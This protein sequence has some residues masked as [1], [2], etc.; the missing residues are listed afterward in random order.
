[1]PCTGDQFSICGDSSR[2]TVYTP[3]TSAAASS[4]TSAAP[5]PTASASPAASLGPYTAQGC[6]VDS[7]SSRALSNR[8]AANS[9]MTAAICAG[10]A[11]AGSY[12]F[13]GTE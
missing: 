4:T 11:K 10:L 12:N 13:F 7:G 8:L 3:A 9:N 2:L 6:W 1:M 5:A